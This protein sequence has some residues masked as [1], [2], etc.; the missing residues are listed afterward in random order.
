MDGIGDV[1][2]GKL[3]LN[4][5]FV[6]IPEEIF[7]V[8]FALMIQK[9]YDLL[10]PTRKNVM[11][12]MVPVLSLALFSNIFRTFLDV[13]ADIMP[14]ISILILFVSTV[15]VYKVRNLKQLLTF[16]ASFVFSYLVGSIIQLSY[17]PLLL[18]TTGIKPDE[19]N[20]YGY[21][22]I[23][24]SLPERVI[25]YCILFYLYNIRTSLVKIKIFRE[26]FSNRI[27]SIITICVFVLN[28]AFVT[29]I[30][31]LVFF[32]RILS[33]LDVAIQFLVI[34][35]VLIF[36]ILNIATLFGVIYNMAAKEKFE[37]MLSKERLE[38][39]VS[40][41]EMYA[42]NKNYRKVNAVVN[43]INKHLKEMGQH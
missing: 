34:E 17:I 41:L 20:N 40:I 13:K 26:I 16:F 9:H 6:S 37:R 38:T 33:C 21:L 5:I 18:N 30:G 22:L 28:V 2:M 3:I 4:I 23:L 32:N 42:N 10:K 24:I 11:R 7:L 29:V 36:P 39:L 1:A 19:L 14:I 31:K 35:G 25:E 12:F 15:I 27:L 8:A 43:D